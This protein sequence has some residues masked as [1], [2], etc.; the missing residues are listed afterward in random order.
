MP[1]LHLDDL[2]KKLDHNQSHRSPLDQGRF[3]I[4]GAIGEASEMRYRIL[5][6]G[7]RYSSLCRDSVVA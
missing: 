1:T 6:I 5:V 2:I 7:A 3:G 4:G